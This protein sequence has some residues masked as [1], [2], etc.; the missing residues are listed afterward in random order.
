MN[1]IPLTISSWNRGIRRLRFSRQ[2]N[3]L[4]ASS[5]H[6]AYPDRLI[7]TI[8]LSSS[9]KL[10]KGL[11]SVQDVMLRTV[12]MTHAAT[13][14][15]GAPGNRNVN[16][17]RSLS[18]GG[19]AVNVG[20]CPVADDLVILERSNNVTVTANVAGTCGIL[21]LNNSN[22]TDA[23]SKAGTAL[24]LPTNACC[25]RNIVTFY[26]GVTNITNNGIIRTQGPPET[27]IIWKSKAIR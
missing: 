8:R 6:L 14:Y 20:V 24:T 1:H 7:S 9:G 2:M 18:A 16:T 22:G 23:A 15:S 5:A 19:D 3:V 13:Y 26:A 4:A 17:T 10:M 27:V 12:S 11:I 21:N 25:T